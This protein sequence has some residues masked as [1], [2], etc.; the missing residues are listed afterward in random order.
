VRSVSPKQSVP[1][2]LGIIAGQGDLPAL[3]A[4][5]ARA[6]DR[7]TFI[8]ALEGQASPDLVAGRNHAWVRL[9]AVGG[10]IDALRAAGCEDVVFAGGVRRPSLLNLGLDGRGAK[11]FARIG[12]VALGDDRLLSVLVKELE[13]EGLNVIGADEVLAGLLVE[14]GVLGR[15]R[16]DELAE[17]DIALGLEVAKVIGALDVGQAV[18]VQ[19][20]IVLGVEGVEGTDALIRRCAG[21]QREGP[22]GVLVKI[23]KPGQER[24]VDLPTVGTDTV[25]AAA[26]AGLRGITIEAGATLVLHRDAVIGAADAANLFLIAATVGP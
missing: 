5:A 16:P 1:P 23:K 13:D 22:G 2:K 4:D 15:H 7:D 10:A 11:L 19:Q 6:Q 24:R 9:G 3:L 25:R 8:L 26:E 14:E 12:K 21:L 20:G 18:V 17:V